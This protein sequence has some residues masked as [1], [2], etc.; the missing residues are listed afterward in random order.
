MGSTK[1]RRSSTVFGLFEL[2]KIH[3]FMPLNA[4]ATTLYPARR[5]PGITPRIEAP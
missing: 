1:P 3:A 4:A 5:R 2:R